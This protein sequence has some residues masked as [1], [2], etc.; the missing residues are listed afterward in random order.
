MKTLLMGAVLLALTSGV[1]MAQPDQ[2]YQSP[3]P[4]DRTFLRKDDKYEGLAPGEGREDTFYAFQNC[5]KIGWI[6]RQKLTRTEWDMAVDQMVK[7]CKMDPL[8]AEEKETIVN[9]LATNYGRR[10]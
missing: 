3:I 7:D 2:Q 10:R 1:A 6:K 5:F 9:Y 4:E 8:E